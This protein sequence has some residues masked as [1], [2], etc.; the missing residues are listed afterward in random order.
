MASPAHS[1]PRLLIQFRNHF[2]QTV[3]R[4]GRVISPSQGRYLCMYVCMYVEGVGQKSGPC[5]ATFNDLLC[6]PY[7][8][9]PKHRTT[10]TQN[11]RIHTPNIH[12][13]SGIRTHDPSV[14]AS[15]DSSCLRLPGYCGRLLYDITIL[16]PQ[17]HRSLSQM[18]RV[19]TQKTVLFTPTSVRASAP[20]HR[21]NR[22][23]LGTEP[24]FTG[25]VS[26]TGYSEISV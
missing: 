6:F 10:Q 18:Y 14:R 16:N 2:S 9:L 1:V 13:M 17:K 5:T 24:C 26:Y 11:K 22:P 15:E 7:R 19:R 4:L 3:G 20:V 21:V 12:A 8:P 23:A 25:E